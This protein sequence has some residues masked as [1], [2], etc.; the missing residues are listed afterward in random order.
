MNNAAILFQEVLLVED[1]APHVLLVQRALRGVVERIETCTTITAALKLLSERRFDLV[2]SDL[3]LPDMKREGAVAA[4]RECAPQVPLVVLTSSATVADGVAAMRAGANDFLVKNF[5]PTFRDVLHLAL[6]RVRNALDAERERA[7]VV[8]DRDLLREAVENSNDGLA[9]VHR[10][11]YVR[12]CN[13][14]FN[15]FMEACGIVGRNV[16]ELPASAIERGEEVVSKVR[17]RFAHLQPGAVWATEVVGNGEVAFDLSVS[18]A[19]DA[20]DESLLVVWVR[21]IR[22]RKR[23]EKLQ[24]DIL[25]TTTH[26]L[27]GPLGAISVSC[28]VLL[29]KPS[30]DDRT[31]ALV[32]RIAASASSAIHLIDEFLS[33]RRLEEGGFVMRPYS[34]ELSPIVKKVV[35][36]YALSAKTRGIDLTSSIP[37]EEL[38]GC[39]DGLG[40]ERVLFNLVSNAIKFTPKGGRVQVGIERLAGGVVLRVTDSGSGMEPSDAQRLFSRYTRLAQ[41]S[42]VSGT[43]L[44]LFIVKCIISAHGGSIDVTSALGQGTVFEVFLPDAPPINERGEVLCLDFA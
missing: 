17:E 21:D 18:A 28:D 11:G 33:V 42:G 3:N 12:Y 7:Q 8:R 25:S 26:D 43:G 40:F 29:D 27:K 22:E 1:E 36:S 24:R 35:E 37:A 16:L 38:L 14:A 15:A 6:S 13:S 4:I 30:A 20:G 44:G 39:V 31:H 2:V 34:Q 9:V 23:R 5:D 19:R 41:H 10:D 32:E